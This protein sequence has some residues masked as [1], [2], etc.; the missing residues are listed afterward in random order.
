MTNQTRRM[1]FCHL[2][3]RGNRWM[4]VSVN[5]ELGRNDRCSPDGAVISA[6]LCA[7]VEG[8]EIVGWTEDSGSR[9]D[10]SERMAIWPRSII[11]PRL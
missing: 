11:G 8:D 1:A 6:L 5:R 4:P 2:L 9:L 7:V 3:L 10:K